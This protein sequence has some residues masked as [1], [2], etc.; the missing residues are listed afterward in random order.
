M[1]R[2]HRKLPA[3]VTVRTEDGRVLATACR[4]AQTPWARL[5]GLLGH[6]L[7]DHAGLWIRPSNSIH[8][9]FMRY[10]IDAVFLDREDRVVRIAADLAPWRVASCRGSRS[11][12]E[13]PAG[14]CS[15][16]ALTPGEQLLA[17]EP[18]D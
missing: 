17:D 10:A 7:P 16:V 3:V 11:V 6:E 18:R 9:F 5:R 8:M 4:V 12:V 2:A 15:R 1:P 14:T 13:L